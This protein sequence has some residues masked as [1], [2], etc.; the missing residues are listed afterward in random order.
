MVSHPQN[1]TGLV[2]LAKLASMLESPESAACRALRDLHPDQSAVPQKAQLCLAAVKA[3]IEHFGS[4]AEVFVTRST[5]R[6]NLIGMHV[7]HRGGFVHPIAIKDVFFIV[8]PR[9]DDE[10]HICNADGDLFP[11][12]RFQMSRELPTHKIEDWDAWCHHEQDERK[13]RA[14]AGHWSNYVKSAVLYVQHI[15]TRDDG[16][17][18]PALRGM[19][20]AVAGNVPLAA[21]LSSSSAIVVGTMEACVK[22]NRIA[23]T[24]ME[25]VEAC[26]LGE[27][28]VGTRGGGG[29]HAAIK[30]GR[31]GHISK[32]G[33]FP[34]TVKAEPFPESYSIVL[35]N[36]L[37]EARKQEGARDVFN[38]RVAS[39]VFGLRMLQLNFPQHAAKMEHLRDVSPRVLGVPEADIY[40]MV[41]S[42]PERTSRPQIVEALP[43]DR[44]LVERTFRSHAEPAAG[45]RVRQVCL[46]GIAECLRSD[47]AGEMLEKGDVRAFGE[48]INISH[49]GDRVTRLLDGKRAANDNSLPDAKLDGLIADA[50]SGD[51]E[52]V[53]RARLWRQPGGYDVSTEEQDTLVDIAR[54]TPGVVGAGLVG[55]GLGGSVIAIVEQQRAQAVVDAMARQYYGP[56]GLPEAAEVVQPEE[57]AGVLEITQEA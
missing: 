30:L 53:E 46:Y 51:P 48:L 17:F 25:L 27:W 31:K 21:G 7:D 20:M 29:D 47:V 41:R 4:E 37:V 34:L 23:M 10:V 32:I 36:S 40:R 2:P 11:P 19:N 28:Y 49:D 44:E 33:S 56:R 3:F 12:A 55:A 14:D 43:H 35:A 42:L 13:E 57:G 26:R 6:I 45:Y 16:S 39:Y 24:P 22:V 8:E 52:R 9:D 54:Q 18:D 5:G 38:E 1:P 15:R 50:E